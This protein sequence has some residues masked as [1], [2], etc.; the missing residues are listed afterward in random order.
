M[1]FAALTVSVIALVVSLVNLAANIE[2]FASIKSLRKLSTISDDVLPLGRDIIATI[3]PAAIR[4]KTSGAAGAVSSYLFL[5]VKCETCNAI[6]Y[7]MNGRQPPG[8]VVI[9]T[10]SSDE[11]ANGWANRYAIAPF[12]FADARGELAT[13][14]G[15]N[16]FPALVLLDVDD[17]VDA[18]HAVPSLRQIENILSEHHQVYIAALA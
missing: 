17:K 11:E 14:C 4:Q 13:E 3:N 7:D 10:A 18:G 2:I 1:S 15:I 12:T 6:A 9:V 8:T 16:V 5:S